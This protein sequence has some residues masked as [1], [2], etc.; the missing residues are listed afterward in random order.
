MR[1]RDRTIASQR[2]KISDLEELLEATTLDGP[3][4]VD[5]QGRYRVAVRPCDLTKANGVAYFAQPRRKGLC[6]YLVGVQT[7]PLVVQLADAVHENYYTVERRSSVKGNNY[8]S[9]RY[10]STSDV[11]KLHGQEKEQIMSDFQQFLVVLCYLR[12]RVD[13]KIL[14]EMFSP[15]AV[16]MWS[17]RIDDAISRWAPRLG[18]VGLELSNLPTDAQFIRDTLPEIFHTLGYPD[19]G[20]LFDGR[21]IKTEVFRRLGYDLQKSFFSS[22]LEHE[23]VRGITACLPW[24]LITATTDLYGARASESLLLGILAADAFADLDPSLYALVDKGFAHCATLFPQLNKVIAPAFKQDGRIIA[25]YASIA[26]ELARLRWPSEKVFATVASWKCLSG[27]VPLE[28]VLSGHLNDA[29]HLA[30]GLANLYKPTLPPGRSLPALERLKRAA[31][32]YL[33]ID[34]ERYAT[35]RNLSVAPDGKHIKVGVDEVCWP[36]EDNAN[37]PCPE[38]DFGTIHE[39]EA[40]EPRPDLWWLTRCAEPIVGAG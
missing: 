28:F 34:G 33:L 32:V 12:G 9:R 16:G 36:H 25:E 39:F 17:Q 31:R 38:H 13:R 19:V 24:G 37:I 14:T 6:Q 35:A 5:A 18:Q 15:N 21:D 8:V 23:A 10:W 7:W 11:R 40:L 4:E 26:R 29:W 30:H 2:E 1:R 3:R 27:T 20:V 22:K